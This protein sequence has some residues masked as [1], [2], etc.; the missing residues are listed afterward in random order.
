MIETIRRIVTRRRE[1]ATDLA[2]HDRIITDLNRA[3]ERLPKGEPITQMVRGTWRAE[4]GDE[5]VEMDMALDLTVLEG[6]SND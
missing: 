5:T 3:L 1:P 2:Y 6:D 4:D